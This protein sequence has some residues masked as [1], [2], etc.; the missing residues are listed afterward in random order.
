MAHSNPVLLPLVPNSQTSA[1]LIYNF[2]TFKNFCQK[3]SRL[4]EKMPGRI[5]TL[6]LYQS[7]RLRKTVASF[8]CPFCIVMP[9]HGRERWEE[10]CWE[11]RGN[12]KHE[13]MMIGDDDEMISFLHSLYNGILRARGE[14][15]TTFCLCFC[16]QNF[17]LLLAY[18]ALENRRT[19]KTLR[20]LL[21]LKWKCLRPVKNVCAQ[22]LCLKK[23][24]LQS[25]VTSF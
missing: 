15:K 25:F 11:G 8:L 18:F 23:K 16:F 24:S 19:L 4:G 9:T 5:P 10:F 6:P 12:G 14:H 22:S 17:A 20:Q 21:A 2:C 7:L 13:M 1:F 3:S